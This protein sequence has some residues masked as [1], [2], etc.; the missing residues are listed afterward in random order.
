[1]PRK[2]VLK[3]FSLVLKPVINGQNLNLHFRKV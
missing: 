3:E 1:L 2:A